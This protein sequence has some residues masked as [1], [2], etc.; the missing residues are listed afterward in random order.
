MTRARGVST[1][2]TVLHLLTLLARAEDGLRAGDIAKA[3]GKSTSTTY[4]LLD[5]LCQERYVVHAENGAYHLAAEAAGLV[6]S[7]RGTPLPAGLGGIVDELFARTHKRVYLAGAHSGQVVIPLV[8]GRQGMPVIPGLGA[9]IGE[10][11]HALAL[12]KI[13]LSLLDERALERYISHGLRAFTPTTIVSA[14][15]LREQLEEIR[16]G[17]VAFD[18]EEFS[19]D[20]CCLALPIRRPGGKPVAAL[21]IS[22]SARCFE[23]ERDALSEALRD[24]ADL[25]S[26]VLAAPMV[27]AISEDPAVLE[28]GHPSNLGSGITTPPIPVHFGEEIKS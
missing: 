4:N 13:A 19:A 25:A 20:F 21:G 27:P 10:N 6:P 18:R 7:E 5:T 9:R 8:R 16:A 26:A 17:A 14:D 12:G 22:M 2:R 23:L 1:A 15:R 24:V 3:L 11:A 28:R